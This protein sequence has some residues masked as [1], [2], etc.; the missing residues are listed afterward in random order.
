MTI[1]PPY[2]ISPS[3]PAAIP[4]TRAE[5]RRLRL[6]PCRTCGGWMGLSEVHTAEAPTVGRVYESSC[7]LCGRGAGAGRARIGSLGRDDM[8]HLLTFVRDLA[9]VVSQALAGEAV[10]AALGLVGRMIALAR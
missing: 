3:R 4:V 8:D 6:G 10:Q 2:R 7:L 5:L 9:A 1:R